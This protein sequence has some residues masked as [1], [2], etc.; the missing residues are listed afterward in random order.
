VVHGP[1]YNTSADMQA[2]QKDQGLAWAKRGHRWDQLQPLFPALTP[3]R[4]SAELLAYLMQPNPQVK[5]DV[6]AAL[7]ALGADELPR[8]ILAVH[9]RH[10]KGGRDGTETVNTTRYIEA[11]EL[12]RMKHGFQT[13]LLMTDSRSPVEEIKAHISRTRAAGDG[14][15][16]LVS[17]DLPEQT[18]T[19]WRG[20]G[21]KHD[22][23]AGVARNN[24][25]ACTIAMH[26]LLNLLVVQQ[27]AGGLVSA[28]NSHFAQNALQLMYAGLGVLPPNLSVDLF[29]TKEDGSNCW[30]GIMCDYGVSKYGKWKPLAPSRKIF[31]KLGTYVELLPEG[32]R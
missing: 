16:A 30:Q 22:A 7:K 27:I 1:E 12:M 29:Y 20:G 11:M 31:G 4:I 6:Q 13:V 23:A 9:V 3:F 28:L 8:P 21:G 15:A 24:D 32:N 2:S 17:L 5:R 14:F 26:C 10:G 18:V 19:S 25:N